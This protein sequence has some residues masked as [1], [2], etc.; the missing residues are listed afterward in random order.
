MNTS[1]TRVLRAALD[2]S[3]ALIMLLACSA[4]PA[5]AAEGG[6][7]LFVANNGIDSGSCGSSNRP[8]RSISQAVANAADGDT[9]WVRPGIY[10][11]LDNDGVF[12]D[13]GDERPASGFDCMICV[14]KDVDIY[15]TRGADLTVI[16]HG[17]ERINAPNVVI[18]LRADGVILG[19]RGRGFTVRGG[20]NQGILITGGSDSRV[21]GNIV[22]VLAHGILAQACNGPIYV[23]QNVA[24]RGSNSG[25]AF[26]TSVALSI[27][28]ERCTDPGPIVVADNVASDNGGT[29][30]GIFDA[31]HVIFQRNVSTRNNVGAY[32]NGPGVLTDSSFIGNRLYGVLVDGG[33]ARLLR[34]TI[35][36]NEGPGIALTPATSEPTTVAASNIFGN[37]VKPSVET[38]LASNCGLFNPSPAAVDARRNFWGAASGPGPDPAD[39]AGPDGSCDT[40]Q[41]VTTVEPF[42]MK[43]LEPRR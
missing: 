35:L 26:Q 29:G 43:Q 13:P 20:A 8:C 21:V 2:R 14:F 9:V 17:D 36:G 19:A 6:R 4:G 5:L 24:T 39:D 30:F 28:G 41:G 31:E 16:S 3:I 40:A 38:P 23:M 1:W 34:S 11:D 18:E 25:D 12:D 37:G 22:Q 33:G 7:A 10:G 32:V 27:G 15:S 42:A